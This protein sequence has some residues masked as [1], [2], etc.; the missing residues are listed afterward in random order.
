MAIVCVSFHQNLT[1]LARHSYAAPK[2]RNHGRSYT[3][4]ED[5]ARPIWS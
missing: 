3:T 5:A 4:S 1:D 2:I